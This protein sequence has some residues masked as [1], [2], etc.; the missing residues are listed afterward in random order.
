MNK[1]QNQENRLLS[2]LIRPSLSPY[3]VSA[4][5]PPRSAG[6]FYADRRIVAPGS[7]IPDFAI[8]NAA[9][10]GFAFRSIKTKPFSLRKR[11][12]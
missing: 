11:A 6:G 10:S 3:T 2:S 8:G 4:E 1:N 5:D 7:N 9:L 12:K